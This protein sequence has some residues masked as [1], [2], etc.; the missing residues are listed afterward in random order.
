[1][2]VPSLY[3]C[4]LAAV[5]FVLFPGTA[6][7]YLDPG[8][9]S[10]VVQAVVGAIAAG[11]FTIKLWWYRLKALFAGNAKGTSTSDM[12]DVPGNENKNSRQ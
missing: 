10:I 3:C 4:F 5:T 11:L 12:A 1:M 8:T 6:H 2:R 9:A 7:A